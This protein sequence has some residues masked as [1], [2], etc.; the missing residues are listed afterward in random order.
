M[1]TNV[2]AT[3]RSRG[4]GMDD[5]DFLAAFESAAIPRDR[6]THR[7]HVRVAFLYLRSF[8]FD[9]ALVR[10]RDGIRALN[11]ANGVQDTPTSGYHETR[12]V[13]WA[14]VIAAAMT[15]DSAHDFDAFARG[16]P[17][18]LRK[19]LLGAYY[20]SARLLGLA[21]RTA[22][23][24]PDVAPLPAVGDAAASR[25]PGTSPMTKKS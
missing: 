18:L 5:R 4:N 2:P 17:S 25:R 22:F 7:D 20:S 24:E 3:P 16:H 13:A 8:R 10:L 19:E 6:W 11:R 23:V 14:R 21:A 15:M 9:D 1:D 12:T